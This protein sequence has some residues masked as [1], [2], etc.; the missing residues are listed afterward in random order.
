MQY[1]TLLSLLRSRLQESLLLRHA[2][3]NVI[4]EQASPCRDKA[5]KTLRIIK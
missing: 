4:E 2:N 5:S 1:L 3:T